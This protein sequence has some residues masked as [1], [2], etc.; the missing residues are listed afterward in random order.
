MRGSRGGEG[1]EEEEE[2]KGI[3][4]ETFI[5]RRVARVRRARPTPR[6]PLPAP[7]PLIETTSHRV[8]PG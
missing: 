3:N 8:Q 4:P 6:L 2:D 7:L 5:A 1:D